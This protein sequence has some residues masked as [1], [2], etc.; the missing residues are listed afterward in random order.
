MT[1]FARPLTLI[2]AAAIVGGFL[3]VLAV[4]GAISDFVEVHRVKK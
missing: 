3:F 4:A 1:A 2:D